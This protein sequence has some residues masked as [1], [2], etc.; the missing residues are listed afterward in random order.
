[1]GESKQVFTERFVFVYLNESLFLAVR[2]FFG[3]ASFQN[4]KKGFLLIFIHTGLTVLINVSK[5]NIKQVISE[6]I[7]FEKQPQTNLM[8]VFLTI[9]LIKWCFRFRC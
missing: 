2:E 3:Q 4:E 8:V 6:K 5:E 7:H 1:M 9:E